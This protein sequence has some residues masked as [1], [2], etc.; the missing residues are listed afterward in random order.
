[1]FFAKNAFKSQITG[2]EAQL[3]FGQHLNILFQVK[4]KNARQNQY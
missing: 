2:L 4:I 3:F 1:M